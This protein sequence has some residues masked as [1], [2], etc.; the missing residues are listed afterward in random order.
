MAHPTSIGSF[1]RSL[2]YEAVDRALADGASYAEARYHSIRGFSF[3]LMNGMLIGTSY[4]DSTGVAVRALYNGGLG[5]SSTDSLRRDHVLEAA[6]KAVKGARSAA[7]MGGSRIGLS[8]ERLGRAR[9]EASQVKPLDGIEDWDKISVIQEIYKSINLDIGVEVKNVLI[10]FSYEFEDK[11]L[12]TSDGALVESR[13]PRVGMFYSLTTQYSGER[14]NRWNQLGGVGGLE[15]VRD[16]KLK[17]SIEDDLASLK[18]YLTKAGKPPKG[19]MDVVL[20]PEVVGLAVHESAGHPSEADRVM[21]REAA[22]AGLSYRRRMKPGEVIG[23]EYATVIDD[24][25]IPGSYGFYLY[26]DEG[27]PA[28]PRYLIRNGVLEEYLHNRETAYAMDTKSNAAARA[29]EWWAEPIVRM[30][31]TYFAPGDYSFEELVEDVK[32]GVYI[33]KYMEWNI[34]DYRWIAR[35]V[36]FEAYEIVDGRIGRP[37]K[38]PALEVNSKEFYSGVDAAGR[39]LEFQAGTCGKGEPGQGVPVW[40]G[41]PHVRLRGVRII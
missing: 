11:I 27:V 39:D 23:S 1:D 5:F 24:P 29:K 6:A 37:V 12:V 20:G 33:K 17:E 25:T 4:T 22:Q 32:H 26:D 28:R 35:Y 18:L 16:L 40:F 19:R 10:G 15:L 9:Y 8:E 13:I 31:N 41:G 2:L 7:A 14:A 38:N 21:G 30:A 3:V 36:G 34:D